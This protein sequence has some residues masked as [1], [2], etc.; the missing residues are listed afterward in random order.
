VETF[1]S[2]EFF[3]IDLAYKDP[4]LLV[5]VTASKRAPRHLDIWELLPRTNCGQCGESTCLAFAVGLLQQKH[6]LDEC[7]PLMTDSSSTDRHAALEAML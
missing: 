1:S 4:A 5:A 3:G 7:L 2:H 6:K